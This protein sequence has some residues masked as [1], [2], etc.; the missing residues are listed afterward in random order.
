[1]AIVVKSKKIKENIYNENGNVLGSISY[2][3]EDVSTYAKLTDIM[4][5]LT[6]ISKEQKKIKNIKNISQ[7]EIENPEGIDFEKYQADFEKLNNTFH[8]CEEEIEKIKKSIDDIF[9]VNTSNILME[10]SNDVEM[11]LPLLE[12]VTPKFKKARDKKVNKYLGTKNKEF[13]VME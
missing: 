5:N 8:K 9:G 6:E 1:M 12:E 4:Q 10:N 7:E 2:N 3:P 13:D 11:L